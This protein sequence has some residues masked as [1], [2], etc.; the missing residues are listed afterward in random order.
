MATLPVAAPPRTP[1]RERPL[2][3]ARWLFAV[4]ALVLAMVVVGGITRLTE[5]GLSIT[6]W[7]PISGTLPPLSHDAWMAEFRAY[8]RIPE[9]QLVNRGMTLGEFQGIFW[10]EYAHRLLGRVVGLAFLL[11]ALWFAAARAIP[12]GY[13]WRL[14]ALFALGGLQGAIGWWMVSSGLTERTDVSHIRLAVHLNTALFTMGGLIWTALDLRAH[15]GGEPP[16]RLKPVAIGALLVLAVQLVLGAF[17]AGLDAGYAYN[18]WPLMGD[19]LFPEGAPMLAPAWA[20]LVDNPLV[21][22]FAH[23]W[24][25]F[26]ALAA[27]IALARAAKRSGVRGA[28]VALH[29]AVG[30]QIL[31]GIATLITGVALWLGV[32]HQFTGALVVA[33]AVWSAHAAGRYSDTRRESPRK[34]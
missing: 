26:V 22:Q 7:K 19:R 27:M 30:T 4:A 1:A 29:A 17:V 11:P 15:A 16:A 9:Y 23:R 32:L 8:Q 20:N 12:R 34:A 33:A 5:S 18:T 21:V 14:A 3:V 2:A 31:L 10:W 24:W 13:G 6:S 25:A 28:S